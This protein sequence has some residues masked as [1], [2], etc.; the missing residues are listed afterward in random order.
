MDFYLE[1]A[2][3]IPNNIR[4]TILEEDFINKAVNTDDPGTP[5]EYL[6][7]VY[8]EF[9]DP[10]GEHDSWTC[11]KCREHILNTWKLMFPYLIKM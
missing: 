2:K 10:I 1:M 8:E 5:M 11:V 9:L 7:D 6:F 3:R 4:K